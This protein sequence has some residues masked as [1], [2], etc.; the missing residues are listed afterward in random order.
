MAGLIESHPQDRAKIA[1]LLQPEQ[2][3]AQLSEEFPLHPE[4]SKYVPA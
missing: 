2:I 4:Q 3:G 1:E